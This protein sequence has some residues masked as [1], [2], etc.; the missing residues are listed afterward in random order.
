MP[1][2]AGGTGSLCALVCRSLDLNLEMQFRGQSIIR[3]EA[4]ADGLALQIPGDPKQDTGGKCDHGA[5]T[6]R[7]AGNTSS[8]CP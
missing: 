7:G 5:R 1:L 4:G 6:A 2:G 8:Q 3:D